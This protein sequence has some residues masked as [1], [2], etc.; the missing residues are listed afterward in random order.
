M[1][2]TQQAYLKASNP[3]PY[4]AFGASVS[5]SGNL[6]GVGAPL[7]DSLAKG[8]NGSQIQNSDSNGGA[9]YLFSRTGD[10][11]AQSAYLKASNTEAGDKFGSTVGVSADTVVVGATGEASKATV[12]NGDQTNNAQSGAGAAYVFTRSNGI[13][14]QQAYLKTSAGGAG[15]FGKTLAISGESILIGSSTTVH[16]F[17]RA[18][19]EWRQQ[20]NLA[21]T[22][23]PRLDTPPVRSVR[24]VAI[25]GDLAIVGAEEIYH[26]SDT[27]VADTATL[28]RRDAL[29]WQPLASA[30]P[31]NAPLMDSRFYTGDSFAAA[32][33]ISG[34]TIVVGSPREDSAALGINGNQSDNSATESG[35]AYIFELGLGSFAPTITVQPHIEG[36]VPQGSTATLQA[37]ASGIPA[38]SFQ[39]YQGN[40]GDIS[41]P[42]TNANWRIFTTPPVTAAATYW[43]RA[44]NAFG[45]ADSAP[46]TLAPPALTLEQWRLAH[47]GA[48]DDSGP[49]ADS[50]D[51]DSDGASNLQEYIAGT[52]PNDP[53]DLFRINAAG[54]QEGGFRLTV[55]GKTGRSYQLIRAAD[56]AAAAWDS[57]VSAGPVSADAPLELNDPTPPA[58]RA[59]YRVI[60]SMP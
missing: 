42:V 12:V 59:F 37:E 5:I 14:S 19:S 30:Q 8:V 40:S 35:A 56:P 58:G 18:G 9:V 21:R 50:A 13:W 31:S 29:G 52:L 53:A 25:S 11:W 39:W 28:F 48:S 15:G 16:S 32:V 4:H 34:D 27:P 43:M 26:S 10:L 33:A 49:A 60:V 51:P 22:V 47:F 1:T 36:T 17:H 20:G 38:P 7:E 57:V 45:T 41:S 46:V 44:T 54:R 55:P 23:D 2:W 3:G 24:S 6:I